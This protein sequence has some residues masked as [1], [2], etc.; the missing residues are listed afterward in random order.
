MVADLCIL[1]KG[2]V[3]LEEVNFMLTGSKSLML[4]TCLGKE[5]RTFFKHLQLL[6]SQL[7]QKSVITCTVPSMCQDTWSALGDRM[8]PIRV[9]ASWAANAVGRRCQVPRWRREEGEDR[10]GGGLGTHSRR[11]FGSLQRAPTSQMSR[12]QS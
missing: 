2:I 12:C 5:F 11:D 1:Y 6:F 7:T 10:M 4:I 3:R 8:C 9:Q